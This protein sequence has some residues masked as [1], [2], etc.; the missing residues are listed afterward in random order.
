MGSF[1]SGERVTP[2]LKYNLHRDGFPSHEMK[3]SEFLTT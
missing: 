3:H 2:N 1:C